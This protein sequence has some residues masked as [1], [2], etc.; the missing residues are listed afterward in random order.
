MR[1]NR[2]IDSLKTRFNGMTR[3]WISKAYPSANRHSVNELYES[4]EHTLDIDGTWQER[5]AKTY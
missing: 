5:N 1:L 3:D 4:K 2:F